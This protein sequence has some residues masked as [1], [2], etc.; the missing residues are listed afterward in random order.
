MYNTIVYLSEIDV[1]SNIYFGDLFNSYSVDFDYFN[2]VDY[3]SDEHLAYVRKFAKR[4]AYQ[5]VGPSGVVVVVNFSTIIPSSAMFSP[6][7]LA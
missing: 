1:D 6:P 7:I 2:K 3:G 4:E 5:N